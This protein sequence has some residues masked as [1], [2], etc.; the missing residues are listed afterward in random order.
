M[1][2]ILLHW[3]GFACGL[4]IALGAEKPQ[5]AT[6]ISERGDHF[7]VWQRVTVESD[8]DGRTISRTNA[9][10]TELATGL[11]VRQPDGSWAEASDE[12]EIIQ[13][14]GIARKTR[15]RVYFAPN[16]NSPV[17][18]DMVTAD[19]KRLRSRILGLAFFDRHS[20][21][22]VLI[23]EIKDAEGQL[24]TETPNEVVYYDAFTDIKADVRYKNSK[25]GLEQDIILREN[26]PSPAEYGLNPATTVLEVLTEF[27]NPP[28]PGKQARII[29]GVPDEDLDFGDLKM[30]NGR[31]FLLGKGATEI[32]VTKQW[33]K[34]DRRTFLIEEIPYQS[35]ERELKALPL[36]KAA[37]K[38]PPNGVRHQVSVKRLLPPVKEAKQ[39]TA[40][41]KLA[42]GRLSGQG[43]VLD[44]TTAS[45]ATN[46]V[47]K[48]DTTYFVSGPVHLGGSITT[49]EGGA[50]FKFTN[51][52][53]VKIE[54]TGGINCQTGPYRPAVFTSMN[55]N[56][57]GE[58]IPGSS[59]NPANDYSNGLVVNTT[60]NTLHDLRFLYASSAVTLGF[61]A[62]QLNLA[63][64]QFVRCQ[65]P[66][67]SSGQDGNAIEIDNG[68][69]YS[70]VHVV[71]GGAD[72]AV[73]GRHLT[74]NQ[75]SMFGFT[76]LF[77]TTGRLYLTNCLVVAATNGWGQFSGNFDAVTTNRTAF[78]T[79]DPADIF[80]TVGAASHYL[81]DN[82]YRDAGTTNIPTLLAHQLTSRTTHPPIVVTTNFTANTI[83]FPQALRD[84]NLPDLGYHYDPLDFVVSG[85][86]VS[87]NLLLTN[88]VAIGTY[89]V[90][91]SYGLGMISGSLVSEGAPTQM[92]WITR[93]NV[94]Q[95]QSVTNWSASSVA[96][97]VKLGAQTRFRF[98]AWSQL[99]NNG[100]HVYAWKPGSGKFAFQDCHFGG[101]GFYFFGDRDGGLTNCLWERV[102]LHLENWKQE[103]DHYLY[104][105]LFRG[106]SVDIGNQD[107]GISTLND[108]L[109]DQTIIN[110]GGTLVHRHNAY[111]AGS[112]RFYPTNA[113]DVVLPDSPVYQTSY[114]GRYYYPTNDG[115]LGRL[116]NVGSRPA[117]NAGLYHYT[118]TTN[119]VK[120]TTSAVDIGF[121]YV[122]LDPVTRRP[123]DTDGDGLQDYREDKNGNG[124]YNSGDPANWNATDTDGDG[125][126]DGTEVIQGRN[127]AA[128]AIPD[129]SNQ[130]QLKVFTPL[131]H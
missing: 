12:I 50:I 57:V 55:D 86:T 18:I 58:P 111:V 65:Y 102:S 17:A 120:E 19:G 16:C 13:S 129:A 116:I 90:S 67:D 48:G 74:V 34:M 2:T 14:G 46:Y 22:S 88:G 131:I 87:A 95:E 98:T 45:S 100:R 56:T 61:N 112:S 127:P 33:G 107:G 25:A 77:A 80:Q 130:T 60:S 20:G 75:C 26:P 69:F 123:V 94:V 70:S 5:A 47:F 21:K 125:V 108:N 35:V 117:A 29:G 113:N 76:G 122:A 7:R 82:T 114:L 53:S 128:G 92:N 51:A 31:V 1:K 42:S 126:N 40:P 66:I 79:N 78:F 23:A 109:F 64:V 73:R 27:F 89:G 104:N 99:G 6:F 10:Y 28:A 62:G 30:G 32:P 36:R 44:Y 124:S 63:N 91:S 106:G 71:R 103:P 15:H 4:T 84:T 52:A 85:R 121:H 115:V 72:L 49:I 54:I 110:Q 81:A 96:P 101:G 8:E 119:Q 118:T 39:T 93:Y 9:A 41:M 38:P 83:L 59:G 11:N 37:L 97:S 24:L 43:V 3:A 68:L 105:N